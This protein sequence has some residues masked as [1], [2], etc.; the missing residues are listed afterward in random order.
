MDVHSSGIATSVIVTFAVFVFVAAVVAIAVAAAAVF[1]V[2]ASIFATHRTFK[3]LLQLACTL[4][5]KLGA[6][7][8][9]ALV[10]VLSG[11]AF[12][13]HEHGRQGVEE[14]DTHLAPETASCSSR[15]AIS[16]PLF[17]PSLRPLFRQ[18]PF[19]SARESLELREIGSENGADL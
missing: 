13:S 14:E 3:R 17:P 16:A 2:I 9:L 15:R 5:G 11:G 1:L 10:V 12:G 19:N 4:F 18:A 8:V 7:C 6:E